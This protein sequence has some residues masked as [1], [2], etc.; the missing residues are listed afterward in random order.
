MHEGLLW[1]L[2]SASYL[3]CMRDLV[4]LH[5]LCT[6]TR[7]LNGQGWHV[8]AEVLKAIHRLLS[9][10]WICEGTWQNWTISRN[11]VPMHNQ[12]LSFPMHKRDKAHL[13]PVDPTMLK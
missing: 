3:A 7:M 11:S 8:S 10:G 12:W 4:G 2:V 6:S 13:M 9:K 1:V 5:L